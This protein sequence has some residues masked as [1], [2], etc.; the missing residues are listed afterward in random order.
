LI[1]WLL[2]L[3]EE[4]P[5]SYSITKKLVVFPLVSIVIP[6]YNEEDSIV[7]TLKSIIT[8]DYPKEKIEVIVVNDG[9]TDDTKELVEGFI[10][11]NSTW[12]IDLINQVNSGKGVAL[13]KGLKKSKGEFFA[14]LDADSFVKKDTLRKIL[15]YFDEGDDVATVLPLM[16]LRDTTTFLQKV[17]WSEYLI[18]FFY[19]KLMGMLDC[20]HVSPG[21]FSVYRSK[22]LKKLGGFDEHNLTED[23]E[24]TLRL[25]KHNY[26]IIQ[27]LNAEVFTKAPKKFNEFYKQRNRWYKGSLINMFN[28]RG[29]IF[30]R[31]YEEFGMQHAPRIATAGILAFSLILITV[32]HFFQPLIQNIVALSHIKFDIFTLLRDFKLNISFLSFNYVNLFF[33]GFIFILGLIIIY[34]AHKFTK[35]NWKS[36]GRLAVPAYLV[37]YSLLLSIVWAGITV[38]FMRGKIQKW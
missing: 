34:Y 32:Y 17:Q 10:Q 16:K 3:L 5:D 30:N 37:L 15:P 13:N 6:A 28:Y 21:P 18:N 9:S 27:T 26:R 24:I 29:L 12:K 2:V 35:E 8:M 36:R 4:D 11:K 38:D 31:K 19:K 25:Q 1:F 14:C 7:E 20:V 33:A 23:L 22:I